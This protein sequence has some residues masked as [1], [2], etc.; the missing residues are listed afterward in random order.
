M[1]LLTTSAASIHQ[2]G[3]A[4][5]VARRSDA[6]LAAAARDG[7][8][9]KSWWTRADAIANLALSGGWLIEQHTLRTHRK[10]DSATEEAVRGKDIAA[11]ASML[12]NVANLVVTGLMK[13]RF[14]DGIA[15]AK[16]GSPS[17][18]ASA[19]AERY[20]LYFRLM[21]P[22]NRA[23]AAAAIGLTPRVNF[24]I[25]RSYRPGTGWRLFT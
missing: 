22:L 11:A 17:R 5:A 19:A 23:L 18:Q 10:L 2:L 8:T 13:R 14:P 21:R 24:N 9:V 20:W 7:G 15:V 16:D 1:S 3:A 4:A 6:T 25:L 12:T